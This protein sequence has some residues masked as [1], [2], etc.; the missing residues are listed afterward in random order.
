MADDGIKN[1]LAFVTAAFGSYPSCRQYLE[2]IERARVQV[3]ESAPQIAKLRLFYNHP[4]FIA[5][6]ADRVWDALEEIPAE[7]RAAARLI[8]TA[9]SIPVSMA[10]HS[11]YEEQL[12]EACQLVAD[13]LH[14]V[15]WQMAYQSRSGP[16]SQPWLEP[17]IGSVLH[18]IADQG[19]TRDVVLA[20]IGFICE[21]MEIVYDLD[22]EIQSL[23]DRLGLN[24]VRSGVVASHPRF[25]KMI[26]ELILERMTEPAERLALGK[27]GPWPDECP[28]GCCQ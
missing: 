16:P 28:K 20:P 15:Q 25:V 19:E 9:H 18:G 21:H 27:S 2:D 23:G 22:V 7:R 14:R 13:H 4:G 24:V 17:D 5:A 26:R 11:P 10:A 12:R 3:G 8:F 6:M 1:A